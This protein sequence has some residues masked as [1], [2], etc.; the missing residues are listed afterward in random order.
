MTR[1]THEEMK[2][3]PSK[4]FMHLKEIAKHPEGFAGWERDD[5]ARIAKNRP[6]AN[7]WAKEVASIFGKK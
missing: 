6:A 7:A 3:S 5:I 4:F 1:K 2:A